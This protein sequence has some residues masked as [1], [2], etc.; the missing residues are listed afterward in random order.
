MEYFINTTLNCHAKCHMFR[1]TNDFPAIFFLSIQAIANPVGKK[2][3]ATPVLNK[4]TGI[5]MTRH[6]GCIPMFIFLDISFLIMKT[7]LLSIYQHDFCPVNIGFDKY[8][9]ALMKWN[10]FGK[11]QAVLPCD[12]L[13]VPSETINT[14][15]MTLHTYP[16]RYPKSVI[17]GI[18]IQRAS[19]NI[20][21]SRHHL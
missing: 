7:D 11:C 8:K 9:E 3:Q 4:I 13:Q 12:N 1:N 6:R 14:V 21:V 17:T 2:L 10:K 20:C 5:S 19:I 16:V 15:E 18:I